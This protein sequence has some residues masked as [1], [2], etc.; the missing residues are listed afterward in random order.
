MKHNIFI[1]DEEIAVEV[2]FKSETEFVVYDL[3]NA[4]NEQRNSLEEK[5]IWLTGY[6]R[7]WNFEEVN[8][9]FTDNYDLSTGFLDLL[10][11]RIK[12]VNSVLKKRASEMLINTL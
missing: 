2:H 8:F 10:I 3:N 5:D 11:E 4:W 6:V 12:F 1:S 7:N 9:C